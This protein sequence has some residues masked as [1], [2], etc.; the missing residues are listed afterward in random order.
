MEKIVARL[1]SNGILLG[2]NL[3]HNEGNEELSKQ[4][5]MDFVDTDIPLFYN[6]EK[7]SV[8]QYL[9]ESRCFSSRLANSSYN[10]F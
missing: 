7:M 5:L 3:V 10:P 9:G 2:F 8:N 4:D 6:E 1:S